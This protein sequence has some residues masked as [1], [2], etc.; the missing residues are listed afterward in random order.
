[1]TAVA[2]HATFAEIVQELREHFSPEQP[3][4]HALRLSSR[5]KATAETYAALGHDVAKLARKAY[6]Q[7]DLE[8]QQRLALETFASAV[9]DGWIREKLRDRRSENMPQALRE[10]QAIAAN[11]EA[12]RARPTSNAAVKTVDVGAGELTIES[13]NRLSA[14]LALLRSDVDKYRAGEQRADEKRPTGTAKAEIDL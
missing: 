4:T 9:A 2:P 8:T 12:E 10:V 1:M 11:R 7:A 13:I 14:Q 5:V 6:P 3:E